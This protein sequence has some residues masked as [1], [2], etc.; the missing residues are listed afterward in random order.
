MAIEIS[1]EKKLGKDGEKLVRMQ[2]SGMLSGDTLPKEYTGSAP[3]VSYWDQTIFV[4]EDAHHT[5][6]EGH[7][8]EKDGVR[9]YLIRW[10]I[11]EETAE[12]LIDV[13]QRS[14]ARLH[15]I[16]ETH[17]KQ[18]AMYEGTTKITI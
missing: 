8:R 10:D 1:M 18:A 5:P 11:N 15:T 9:E 16:M 13:I 4:R 6:S 12:Y 17:R 3:A 14:G 2:V 7:H